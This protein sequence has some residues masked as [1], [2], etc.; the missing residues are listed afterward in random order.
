MSGICAAA[1]FDGTEVPRDVADAMAGAAPYRGLEGTTAWHGPGVAIVHQSTPVTPLDRLGAR[2]VTR[3][4]L[5][6]VADARIDNRDELAAE[7]LARGY[8]AAD[9]GTTSDAEL[10]LAAHRCW[11]DVA[12]ARL[13]GD[14]AYVLWD[15]RRRRM[16]AARDPMGMRPLYHRI[17]PGRRALIA[18]E[19]KQLL[20]APG[21]PC[22]IDERGIVATLAG[23]YLAADETVYAGIGQVPAGHVLAVDVDGVTV[24]PGW[25]P[26]PDRR[27]RMDDE[28]AAATFRD[29]LARAVEDRLGGVR[30]P[31]LLLSGGMDS[32]SIAATAGWL[33]RAGRLPGEPLRTYSWSFPSLPDAD[34]RAVSDTIVTYHALA[35]VAV[36]GDDLWP[37]AGYP[38][39]GP[40]RDDPF[41]WP[42]QGLHDRTI[43]AAA[44]DGIGVLMTGD[45]GDELVGDWVHDE[46]GLLRAGRPLAALADLRL[47]SRTDDRSPVASVRRH[48]VRPWLWHHAPRLL[49]AAD[50][51]RSPTRPW[52]PW[53]S[54]EAARRV[55]LCDIITDAVRLPRFDGYARSLRH[56]R[57]CLA[58]AARLA[59]LGE[60]S[61]ARSGLA[62]ADPFTDRRLIELV[63]ALPPWRI[64]RRGQPKSILRR[65]MRGVMPDVALQRAGKN[66]PVS[67]FD[68]GLRDRAVET[69]RSLLTDSQV[70][71]R[72][73]LDAA[74]ASEAYETYVRTGESRFDPWWPLVVEWWLRRWWS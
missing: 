51:R 70:V 33:A 2:P 35:N 74:K 64:Q 1:T 45:R 56:Q 67:L 36:G 47:A 63:L 49:D 68:R 14:F 66:I 43:A 58:Q 18:S 28:T 48:L 4:G 12:A 7:L 13:V 26:D 65:A 54:D 21:V 9:P 24:R 30:P 31:G 29:T 22:E 20:A 11:G 41:I 69:A 60:R 61:R 15:G 57:L 8:M 5:T 10:I 53:I 25:V 27:L 50:R 71:A 16:L 39:G 46:L 6:L 17:E 34:E 72:G 62:F 38:Y 32:G 19:I 3:A 55:D 44:A 37:L 42:Y 73:W 40:D 52:A 23:P 59:S